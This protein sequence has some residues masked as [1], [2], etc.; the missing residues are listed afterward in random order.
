[1]PR[2]KD[3]PRKLSAAQLAR[4][5]AIA[6]KVTRAFEQLYLVTDK[7]YQSASCLRQAVSALDARRR[8]ERPR[9]RR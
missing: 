1:M 4:L 2:T 9:A 8:R 3:R 6:D 7:L 5:E